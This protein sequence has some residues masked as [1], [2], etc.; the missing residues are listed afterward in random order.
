MRAVN[1]IPA[2]SRRGSSGP[3]KSGGAVY[4]VLGVLGLLVVLACAYAVSSKSVKDREAELAVVQAKAT[5]AEAKAGALAPYTQFAALRANRVQTVRSLAAS[6]FDWAHAL[7]EVSRT[8]PT[9]AWLT[10]LNGTIAPGIGGASGASAGGGLREALPV[11]AFEIVG[12]TT[13]HRS[14]SRLIARMRLIDGVQRVS[15]SSSEKIDAAGAGGGAGGVAGGGA[16]CRN[17]NDRFPKFEL[18]VFFKAVEAAPA[19]APAATPGAPATTTSS[20]T[21]SST[22][23]A[24]PASTPASTPGSAK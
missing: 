7:R 17:G 3:G 24:T 23:T 14:V 15:L 12:C 11:P 5:V 2:E 4:G 13:S 6:R 22:T 10:S 21:T 1:L 9:N 16:D 8:I 19:S 20:T 18:V